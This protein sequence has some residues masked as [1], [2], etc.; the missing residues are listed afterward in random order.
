MK[1]E[2][3]R[4]GWKN[5]TLGKVLTFQRGFDITKRQLQPGEYDV[6]FSS[7]LG[8]KHNEYKV[9]SPGVV[10]GRKG[11]LGTV[12]FAKSNF[13]ATDTTLWVKDF[14]GND[15]KFAYYFLQ[16]LHL[17]QYDCGSANPTLNRNHIHELPI[18]Y[19]SLPTQK[20]IAGIL[21]AY[22]DLIE[23]N[24]R[25]IKILEEMA[26]TLYHEWFVKFRFPGH[27]HTILKDICESIVDCEHKTAPIQATGY[28]S[29]RTP[30]IGKG[31]LL[32][33]KVNRVSEEIYQ[34]WTKR[35]IPQTNDLILAREAPIGN[36][37]II[38]SNLKLCLGQRTVLIRP[39]KN[40]VE[41]YYLLYS[42]LSDEIQTKFLA[43]SNGATVHHLNMKDI[44]DLELPKFAPI[45]IQ[46]KFNYIVSNYYEL[47]FNLM[48]KNSNLRQSRDLLLPKLIS[49]EI[50]VEHLEITIEDIA[51]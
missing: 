17:E 14:H 21:S 22:D 29:I 41:P 37:A 25:R 47:I 1:S 27:K 45:S 13:W 2:L 5:I 11:T 46:K 12:F 33:D 28:P 32:L 3:F 42:L 40:K 35:A 24:T 38:P 23:N 26:Q 34:M 50:D 48:E 44:R 15:E 16:T 51:A 18:S 30:N 43:F 8:G 39:D 31:L 20:K 4:K 6:I 49:G 36:V 19:P 10:I 7:G 9:K